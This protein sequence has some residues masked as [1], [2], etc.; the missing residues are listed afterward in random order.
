MVLHLP[1]GILA[2]PQMALQETL[3]VHYNIELDQALL[4]DLIAMTPFAH[5]GQRE[6]RERLLQS[7]QL[8]VQMAFSLRLF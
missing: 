5:R 4:H 3:E 7:D 1:A 8:S 6:K 2:L